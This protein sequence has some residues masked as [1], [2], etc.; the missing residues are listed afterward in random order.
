MSNDDSRSNLAVA[1][2]PMYGSRLLPADLAAE[3]ELV[4]FVSGLGFGSLDRAELTSF[5]GRNENW[6]GRTD[7][8]HRI[9]VKKIPRLDADLRR[10]FDEFDRSVSFERC[11]TGPAAARAPRSPRCLGWDPAS[12]AL[13]FDLVDDTRSGAE[14]VATDEID[15]AFGHEAGLLVGQ[16][17]TMPHDPAAL[18]T[19]PPP[20][21]AL[22]WLEALPWALLVN[23]SMGELEALSI[24]QRDDELRGALRELRRVEAAATHCPAHCDMRLDQFLVGTDGLWMVDWEEFRLAD[25]ARDIGTFAGEIL[26]TMAFGI[27]QSGADA[28]TESSHEEPSHD[29]IVGRGL[30]ALHRHRPVIEAFCAGYREVRPLGED[31][32]ARAAA[33]AGWHLFDRMYVSARERS[34]LSPLHRAAAGIGRRTLLRPHDAAPVLGLGLGLR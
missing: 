25:P 18:D 34:R 29:E 10:R 13:I 32:A 12:G 26:S 5:G 1:E 17:H 8:G 24:M 27:R 4:R 6:A 23:S 33:F 11:R 9:F 7:R 21:P 31:V 30:A 3:P 14:L 19:S 16:L 22:D 20:L 15:E 2:P 28:A